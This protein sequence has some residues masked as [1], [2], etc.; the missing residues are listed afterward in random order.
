MAIFRLLWKL[1]Y[2]FSLG[3]LKWLLAS[4][5]LSRVNSKSSTTEIKEKILAKFKRLSLILSLEVHLVSGRKIWIL[6]SK[7]L[8]R[9]LG[10]AGCAMLLTPRIL[11]S[12]AGCRTMVIFTV[13]CKI[14]A[15]ESNTYWFHVKLIF[16]AIFGQ[17][18]KSDVRA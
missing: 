16:I 13:F 18:F 3:Y 14:G 11:E 2:I 6:W 7:S 15:L 10:I 9:L 8:Y 12:L 5:G 1:N 17:S 4:R